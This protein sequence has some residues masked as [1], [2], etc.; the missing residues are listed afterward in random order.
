MNKLAKLLGKAF[1]CLI[2]VCLIFIFS[3]YSFAKNVGILHASLVSEITT[4]EPIEVRARIVKVEILRHVCVLKIISETY[5]NKSIVLRNCK[6]NVGQGNGYV[7][8]LYCGKVFSF[9]NFR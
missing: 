5:R 4:C 8:G 6:I 2:T 1:V 9:L 3:P 7:V